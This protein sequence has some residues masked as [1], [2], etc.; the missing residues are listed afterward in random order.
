M[1]LLRGAGH[2]ARSGLGWVVAAALAIV[3]Q[4]TASAARLH[5]LATFTDS[6]TA[7]WQIISGPSLASDVLPSVGRAVAGFFI[8][9]AMGITC[10]LPIGFFRPVD[11]WVRPLLEFF[12]AVPPPLALPLAMLV[13]GVS[14]RMEVAIIVFGCLWPV[15]LNAID[16][17]RR[18]DDLLL[19]TARVSRTGTLGLL[20]T[21]VL[22]ASLPQ[23]FAGLRIALSTS[24]IM[25]VVAEMLAANSG[26]GYVILNAQQTF[27]VNLTYGGV[28][29]LALLGWLFDAAFLQAEQ[30]VLAW[31]LLRGREIHV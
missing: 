19:D 13:L 4:A 14:W 3:W 6:A 17:A 25:L 8:A 9:S 22:P 30:R 20:L 11:P 18:V 28:L 26:I 27:Q 23:I 1:I 15:L 24:L 21:V 29:V 10:G 5:S 31:H 7:C 2:F 16:G 12:R